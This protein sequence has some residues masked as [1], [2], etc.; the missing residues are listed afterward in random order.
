MAVKSNVTTHPVGRLKT[1]FCIIK[2]SFPGQIL[3]KKQGVPGPA[4]YMRRST[5][6]CRYGTATS[7]QPFYP[8]LNFV[9]SNNRHF[10]FLG[11]TKFF[12]YI[13]KRKKYLKDIFVMFILFFLKI[14][15]V[16]LENLAL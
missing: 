12:L 4:F 3:A 11:T 14:F 6:A 9:L 5:N 7:N 2:F 13:F 16:L 1:N 10:G 8:T 15:V